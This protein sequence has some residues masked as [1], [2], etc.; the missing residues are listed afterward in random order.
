MEELAYVC[1]SS[2]VVWCGVVWCGVVWCGVVWCG[3][4][5]CGVVYVCVWFRALH[6]YFLINTSIITFFYIHPVLYCILDQ[7]ELYIL[8][9]LFCNKC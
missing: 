1:E 5:W 2:G 3:V 6:N 7:C 8:M 9:F 4:V